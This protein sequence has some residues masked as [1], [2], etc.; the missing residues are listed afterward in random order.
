MKKLF[1]ELQQTLKRT[2]EPES[3]PVTLTEVKRAIGLGDITTE[4]DRLNDLIPVAVAEVEEHARRA[5][6]PQEWTLYLDR[7]PRVIELNRPPI[8]SVDSVAYIDPDGN[9]QTVNASLYEVDTT[10]EPGRVMPIPD[11]YWPETERVP[12]AVQVV[13]QA[14]YSGAIPPAAWQAIVRKVK[15]LYYE[16]DSDDGYWHFIDQLRWGGVLV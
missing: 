13:F 9:P 11:G 1:H 4:D 5:L 6:M 2:G 3:F 8:I 10:S 16:C 7:F 15:A 14:G 12:N